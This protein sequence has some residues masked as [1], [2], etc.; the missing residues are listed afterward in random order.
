MAGLDERS[1]Q[2]HRP[3]PLFRTREPNAGVTRLSDRRPGG[4][5]G[6]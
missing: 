4:Q 3:A 5:D 2:L 1:F 6:S